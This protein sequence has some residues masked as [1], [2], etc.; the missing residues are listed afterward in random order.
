MSTRQPVPTLP[1]QRPNFPVEEETQP[2]G[3]AQMQVENAHHVVRSRAYSFVVDATGQPIELGSG[4][5]A[6][7][8]LGEEHWLESKTAFRRRVAIK[9]LQKGVGHE[10]GLRFQMEKELLEHAQGHPNI[11]TLYAS[12]ESDNPDFVPPA[13]CDKVENDFLVLELC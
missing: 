2:R 7:A 6:K 10:D 11:V 8:Y 3:Q 1:P 5:F 12:G 4:R 13:I 9:I